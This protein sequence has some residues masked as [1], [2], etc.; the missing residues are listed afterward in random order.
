MWFYSHQIA[1]NCIKGFGEVNKC[2]LFIFSLE[3]AENKC[4]FP[5]MHSGWGQHLA[6]ESLDIH[7]LICMCAWLETCRQSLQS[8][9]PS[10]FRR[11]LPPRHPLSL[12]YS[13]SGASTQSRGLLNSSRHI[14][15]QDWLLILWSQH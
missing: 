12:L 1:V 9:V 13:G 7:Y 15:P 8:E 6:G 11:H 10:G 3:K 4:L 5:V 14:V 2:W